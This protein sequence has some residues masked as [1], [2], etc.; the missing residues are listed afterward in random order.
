V[1]PDALTEAAQADGIQVRRILMTEKVRWRNTR[2]WATS[3]AP[4]FASKGLRSSSSTPT[5]RRGPR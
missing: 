4:E 3:D 5:R 2:S 1:D